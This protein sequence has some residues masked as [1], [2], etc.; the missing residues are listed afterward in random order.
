M[1]CEFASYL[2]KLASE[3]GFR[4]MF[5]FDTAGSI[6]FKDYLYQLLYKYA[7]AQRGQGFGPGAPGARRAANQSIGLCP[8]GVPGVVRGLAHAS[9]DR[10]SFLL[11]YQGFA[12]EVTSPFYVYLVLFI[13]KLPSCPLPLAG[14]LARRGFSGARRADSIGYQ[15]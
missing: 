2:F 13:A 5:G 9:V 12:F 6:L 7:G 11:G 15:P 8:Y 1:Y 14:S 3:P 10:T 4:T